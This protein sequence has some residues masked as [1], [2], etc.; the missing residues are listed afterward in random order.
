MAV[1][2]GTVGGRP[3]GWIPELRGVECIDVVLLDPERFQLVRRREIFGR[4]DDDRGNWD[5]LGQIARR[6]QDLLLK[7]R[8][9]ERGRFSGSREEEFRTYIHRDTVVEAP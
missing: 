4:R 9:G 6:G 8:N 7:L 1:S 5:E 2:D 3:V